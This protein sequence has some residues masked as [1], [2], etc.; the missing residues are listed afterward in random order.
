M[1]INITLKLNINFWHHETNKKKYPTWGEMLISHPKKTREIKKNINGK[2]N[3]V[4][5]NLNTDLYVR[6]WT[7]GRELWLWHMIQTRVWMCGVCSA[8]SGRDLSTISDVFIWHD[9]FLLGFL[10]QSSPLV[11]LSPLK[12]AGPWPLQHWPSKPSPIQLEAHGGTALFPPTGNIPFSRRDNFIHLVHHCIQLNTETMQTLEWIELACVHVLRTG[13]KEEV[14]CLN[15]FI[16]T[17][18]VHAL[19]RFGKTRILRFIW[20]RELMGWSVTREEDEV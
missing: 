19:L 17:E 10:S 6:L 20:V 1:T 11:S 4:K 5:N 13:K 3:K 8:T 16:L 18:K 9:W 7:S 2:K 15:F 14:W 12:A